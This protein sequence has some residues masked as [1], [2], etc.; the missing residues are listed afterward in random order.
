MDLVA[1]AA[2]ESDRARGA[3]MMVSRAGALVDKHGDAAAYDLVVTLARLS[4][5]AKPG[6]RSTPKP[7][8]SAAGAR[9]TG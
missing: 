8:P 4:V 5:P 1:L 3:A 2:E 7:T 9:G 6:A